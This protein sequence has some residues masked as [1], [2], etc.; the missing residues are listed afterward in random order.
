MMRDDRLN[1]DRF[2]IELLLDADIIA[3]APAV[4]APVTAPDFESE[5]NG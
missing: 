2:R 3:V 5:D 1:A 4:A